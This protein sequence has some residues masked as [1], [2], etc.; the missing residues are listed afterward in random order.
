MY[1]LSYKNPQS[2]PIVPNETSLIRNLRKKSSPIDVAS[3]S[4]SG[5]NSP[6]PTP[7]YYSVYVAT[8]V[9]LGLTWDYRTRTTASCLQ[10]SL[11]LMKILNEVPW[12]EEALGKG[13]QTSTFRPK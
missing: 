2:H 12:I 6:L 10:C 1:S 11:P 13:Q 8:W 9:G 7:T 3:I 4:N 5:A